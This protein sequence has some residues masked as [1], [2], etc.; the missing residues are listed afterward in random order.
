[1]SLAI[2]SVT[3]L[4]TYVLND[5]PY[6][7]ILE[8]LVLGTSSI[9]AIVISVGLLS[10]QLA[11]TQ[12]TPL[13]VKT[14][15]NYSYVLDYFW[16][17][18]FAIVTILVSYLIVSSSSPDIVPT[19]SRL[20]KAGA[21]IIFGIAVGITAFAIISIQ[22]LFDKTL[23]A[24]DRNNIL[25]N[26]SSSV[27]A[28]DVK[29]YIDKK[30]SEGSTVRHP[31]LLIYTMAKNSIE[32]A[33]T[34]ASREALNHLKKGTENILNTTMKEDVIEVIEKDGMKDLFE[35]WEDL[36][37]LSIE[38]NMRTIVWFWIDCFDSVIEV[39]FS[40]SPEVV[41]ENALQ[42]YEKITVRV[43]SEI[44]LGDEPKKLL[45]FLQ[46]LTDQNRWDLLDSALSSSSSIIQRSIQEQNKRFT[47]E[48]EKL[49]DVFFESWCEVLE[50]STTED[51]GIPEKYD[52]SLSEFID[53]FS[54]PIDVHDIE[55]MASHPYL[56]TKLGEVGET[57]AKEGA[58]ETVKIV[59]SIL[60][61]LFVSTR[62]PQRTGA[63][64]SQV[65][66]EEYVEVLE[67]INDAGGV[68]ATAD[69]FHDLETLPRLEIG[70]DDSAFEAY[71]DLTSE[72]GEG[73]DWHF[74]R[75][76]GFY[77]GRDVIQEL[78]GELADEANID[79]EP[80]S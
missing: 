6:Q 58:D 66:Q 67:M 37:V 10:V 12:Y 57:A 56:V 23:S 31:T 9:L 76:N 22:D 50:N 41:V 49:L 48:T 77:R 39:C 65:S 69:L 47:D 64:M 33:N 15:K 59:V 36:G 73:E 13:V 17:F 1:M 79:F 78:I 7:R 4:I 42:T 75:F 2:A 18:I 54:N 30:N 71:S 38:N 3:F 44:G 46:E 74:V 34:H 21:S 40:N 52:S 8:L 5:V 55:L 27:T 43:I 80:K 53:L 19:N 16:R 25:E 51:D 24:I 26:I 63:L 60:V 72:I 62:N 45:S 32:E 11:A 28:G 14:K 29:E 20:N 68:E 35:F 70:E 61:D